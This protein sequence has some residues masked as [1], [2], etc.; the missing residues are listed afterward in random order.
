M[1]RLSADR[2][3]WVDSGSGKRTNEVTGIGSDGVKYSDF[4]AVKVVIV[5]AL[6]VVMLVEIA[7]VFN[8]INRIFS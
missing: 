6:V 7:V 2:L 8:G 5:M 4:S 1:R 3:P